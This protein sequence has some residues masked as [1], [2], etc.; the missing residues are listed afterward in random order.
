MS[1]DPPKRPFFPRLV[2]NWVSLIGA[3]L[4]VS[5]WFAFF[6]LLTLDFIA[7]GKNPYLGIL[8]YLVAPF[9]FLL[10]LIL[11]GIGWFIQRH[12]A[13]RTAPGA[14]ATRFT[15]DISRP[16]DRK[17]LLGF[18]VGGSTFLLIT[19]VGSYET[20]EATKSVQFCGQACHTPMEP[21]FITYQHSPHARVEC[22][23]CHIGPGPKGFV[24]AKFNGLHQVFATISD[25]YPRPIHKTQ[26]I[27]ID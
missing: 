4:V 17:I 3:I 24:A 16:R 19:A 13:A 27:Q 11:W 7:P 23:H 6:L 14:P 20:Y 26:K 2:R 22:T 18:V 9:F 5:S 10:G 1:S 25:D 15:I 8:T 12:Q 21:Q